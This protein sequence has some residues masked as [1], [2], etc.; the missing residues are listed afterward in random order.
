[1]GAG[2]R[3][4]VAWPSV[5]HSGC[6]LQ[7]RPVRERGE[8]RAAAVG[9]CCSFLP[10]K[11]QVQP[12]VL[13]AYR[14]PRPN[15]QRKSHS[16][17]L[18]V[19]V[20]C[21]CDRQHSLSLSVWGAAHAG[22]QD[23]SSVRLPAS[24]CVGCRVLPRRLNLE[25]CTV[26]MAILKRQFCGGVGNTLPGRALSARLLG[27]SLP[28]APPPEKK[29]GFAMGSE[30]LA[31]LSTGMRN[32]TSSRTS[33]RLHLSASASH[34]FP[35]PGHSFPFPRTGSKLLF[36]ASNAKMKPEPLPVKRVGQSRPTSRTHI[37]SRERYFSQP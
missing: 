15:R 6:L 11:D 36:R 27:S 20:Y 35:F 18:W 9:L 24:C 4:C 25:A 29:T 23:Q 21:R 16:H 37:T 33:S 26:K 3:S 10:A 7:E 22:Q 2:G 32:R 12:Y 28:P 1:M 31:R 30:G 13:A 8:T 34:S 14:P 19:W 17:P 5:M